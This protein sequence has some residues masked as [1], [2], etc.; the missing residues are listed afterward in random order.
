MNEQAKNGRDANGAGLAMME[1]RYYVQ[2]LTAQVFLI[3][4]RVSADREPGP[5]DRLVRSSLFSMMHIC[6][7]V[8]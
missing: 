3:R 6:M 2:V 7:Q 8:V 4:E 1:D 5:G